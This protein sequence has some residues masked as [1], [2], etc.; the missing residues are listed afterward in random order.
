[1]QQCL[2]WIP[3]ADR[4]DAD[5]ADLYE[6]LVEDTD[7]KMQVKIE[8]LTRDLELASPEAKPSLSFEIDK[9]TSMHKNLLQMQLELWSDHRIAA[10]GTEGDGSCGAEMLVAFTESSHSALCVAQ[11]L[12]AEREDMAQILAQCREELALMWR[13]VCSDPAWRS[14]WKFFCAGHV[15]LQKYK[16]LDTSSYDHGT[17]DQSKPAPDAAT[18]EKGYH[19]MSASLVPGGDAPLESVTAVVSCRDG[20]PPKKKKRTGK[21]LPPCDKIKYNKYFSIWLAEKG[22]TYRIWMSQH[23]KGM[24]VVYLA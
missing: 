4:S 21:A 5:A 1:M 14:I 17:P 13:W 11:G 9:A 10:I 23:C 19:P 20:S 12:V 2:H 22:L 18:P 16:A 8:S 6:K 24:V 3:A 7:A 15:N